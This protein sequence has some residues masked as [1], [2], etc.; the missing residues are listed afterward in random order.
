[1]QGSI[2]RL[3]VS[4]V[5]LVRNWSAANPLNNTLSFN[6]CLM[7][8]SMSVVSSIPKEQNLWACSWVTP[9][10]VVTLEKPIVRKLLYTCL[11]CCK[12]QISL[13]CLPTLY[14]ATVCTLT[15]Y[16]HVNII[17]IRTRRSS[18]TESH[19]FLSTDTRLFLTTI[20]T[21]AARHVIGRLVNN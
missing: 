14:P 10:N 16:F 21:L 20:T 11:N 6:F 1:V 15:S 3:E 7:D 12:T 2:N 5:T 8:P 4:P 9:L 18:T 19:V 17:L 13:P